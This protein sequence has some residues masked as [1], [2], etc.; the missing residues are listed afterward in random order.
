VLGCFFFG[1]YC[2]FVG[3][4]VLG[5]EDFFGQ[6]YQGLVAGYESYVQVEDGALAD[7]EAGA[8][9]GSPEGG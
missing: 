5:V 3:V 4:G 7:V 6:A 9:D 8:G 2:Y 1:L